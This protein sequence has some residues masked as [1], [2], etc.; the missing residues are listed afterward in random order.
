MAYENNTLLSVGYRWET[1]FGVPAS[2]SFTT[3]PVVEATP[4]VGHR[5]L[6]VG[7]MQQRLHA[8]ADSK[9]ADKSNAAYTMKVY[10]VGAL[11]SGITGSVPSAPP[12]VDLLHNSFGGCI[13]GQ[14]ARVVSATSTQITVTTTSGSQWK[15]GMAVGF[16][17]AGVRMECVPV[18]SRSADVLYLAHPLTYTPAASDRVYNGYNIYLTQDPTGSIQI[19]H[20]GMDDDDK[21][22]IAGLK[23]G[24]SLETPTRDMPTFTFNLVGAD[25]AS[26]TAASL[27]IDS[28]ATG[29]D[30]PPLFQDSRVVLTDAPASVSTTAS[31]AVVDVAE[32]THGWALEYSQLPSPSGRN[33]ILRHRMKRT[34]AANPELSLYYDDNTLWRKM[35]EST[36]QLLTVQIGSQPGNTIFV[37]YPK[38]QITNIERTS[39]ADETAGTKVTL[40]TDIDRTTA[41]GE[42]EPVAISAIRV[43]VF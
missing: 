23:G 39:V 2:A 43:T 19:Q 42:S 33:G 17:S 41:R 13:S 25:W 1:S 28:L 24:V 35:A 21:W 11:G 37:Q 22:L 15:P 9:I 30:V 32:V 7:V 31:L 4:T 38:C 3:I 29:L 14:G 12:L 16:L 27:G 34:M 36:D 20:L 10:G 26:G 40:T 18:L 8:R 5:V 6:E